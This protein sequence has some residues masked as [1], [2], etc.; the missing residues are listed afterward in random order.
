[1][2]HQKSVAVAS[3]NIANANTPGYS[4]QRANLAPNTAIVWPQGA[5]GTGVHVAGV[6]R[7]RDTLLDQSVR[8]HA[9][10]ASGFGQRSAALTRIETALAEPTDA[11]LAATMDAFWGAWSD[12]S[13]N[14]TSSAARIQ[15][16]ERGKAVGAVFQR[17]DRGIQEARDS[18]TSGLSGDLARVNEIGAQIAE[19]NLRIVDTES[20]GGATANDL[21]DQRDLLTDELATYIPVQVVERDN[22]ASG[23]YI[24]GVA[25]VDGPHTR[26]LSMATVGTQ[27]EI[28]TAGGSLVNAT[29]GKLGGAFDLINNELP[30]MEAQLDALAAGFVSGVNAVHQTGTSP[31]GTTGVDFF[32]PTGITARDI[33]LSVAVEA[34]HL[35]IAAGTPDG[36]GQYQ[37][38]ENDVALQLAALRDTTQASLGGQTFGAYYGDFVTDVGLSVSSA[39]SG[40]EANEALRGQAEARR[41]EVSGV[42]V[43]EELVD[44]MRFQQAYSAAARLITTADEMLQTVLGMV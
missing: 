35:E 30:A 32:D 6:E 29:T 15:V 18:A 39:N 19:I 16:A 37:A 20:G 2:T 34:D 10:L 23:V 31:N 17:M 22:G 12:L 38:G 7:A 28:R 33:A 14:P 21:R 8:D 11:G 44:L 25:F 43:D 24:E 9:S 26:P 3:H 13:N 5:I 36:L 40:M 1:L 42:S 41:S 27:V 4:R